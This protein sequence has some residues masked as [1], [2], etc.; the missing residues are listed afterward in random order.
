VLLAGG[1]GA[2]FAGLGI[3]VHTRLRPRS[4]GMPHGDV[5]QT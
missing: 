5:T 4:G 1:L 3:A 2:I